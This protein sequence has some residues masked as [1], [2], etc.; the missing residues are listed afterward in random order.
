MLMV[1]ADRV[2]RQLD[3]VFSTWGMEASFRE[4][5]VEKIVEADPDIIIGISIGGPPGTPKTTDILATTPVWSGLTAVK[6]GRVY[7]VDPVIYLES[8]GP[9]VSEILDE[10][11]GILYPDVFK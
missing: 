5:C 3:S 11:P 2:R 7:E 10:L 8:A 1:P 6:E 9:R 4:V